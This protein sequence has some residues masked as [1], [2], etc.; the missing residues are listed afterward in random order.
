MTLL[1]A[2]KLFAHGLYY[3]AGLPDSKKCEAEC[4][5]WSRLVLDAY[6]KAGC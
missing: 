3:V 1:I 2:D 4:I 6:V 5:A